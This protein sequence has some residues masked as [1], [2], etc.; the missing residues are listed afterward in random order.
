MKNLKNIKMSKT[1]KSLRK[2][3]YDMD[4]GE[5]KKGDLKQVNELKAL[6]DSQEYWDLQFTINDGSGDKLQ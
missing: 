5:N 1:K 4:F 6:D 2:I 3:R